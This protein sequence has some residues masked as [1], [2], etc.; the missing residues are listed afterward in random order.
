MDLGVGSELDGDFVDEHD[1]A[2]REDCGGAVTMYGAKVAE[3]KHPENVEGSGTILKK[4]YCP[5]FGLGLGGSGWGDVEVG[6]GL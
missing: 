1:C 3:L 5:C 6:L 4:G 2:S